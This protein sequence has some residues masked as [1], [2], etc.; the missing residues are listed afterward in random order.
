MASQLM[1]ILTSERLR[2][3]TV[4][5]VPSGT[6]VSSDLDS[7]FTLYEF[8]SNSGL[9]PVVFVQGSQGGQYIEEPSGIARC[10]KAFDSLRESDFNPRDSLKLIAEVRKSYTDLA[11]QSH[12]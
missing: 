9:S 5:V 3:V 12:L 1:K 10:R 8:E 7:G 11:G 6:K 4:Q 2:G